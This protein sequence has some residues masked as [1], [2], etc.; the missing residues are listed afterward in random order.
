L[1]RDQIR[2]VLR[3]AQLTA[4]RLRRGVRPRLV[5]KLTVPVAAETAQWT[6]VVS[7]LSALL[8]QPA[9]RHA[10]AV[11]ILSNQF[12]RYQLLSASSARLNDKEQLARAQHVYAKLYGE[13]AAAMHLQIARAGFAAPVLV[14]GTEKALIDAIRQSFAEPSLKLVSIQPYLMSAF[15]ACCRRVDAR[16]QWFVAQEEGAIC[17]ALIHRG[18]W[19]SLRMQHTSTNWL[20]DL[21]HLLNREQVTSALAEQTRTVRICLLNG[22]MAQAP[23]I[24]GWALTLL[25]P[26]PIA[27]VSPLTDAAYHA[28]LAGAR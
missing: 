16:A 3:P 4:V 6:P 9:W 2:I 1:W 7:A 10:D 20:Q 24:D 27:G 22:D 25:Q 19:E 12:V 28:A 26:S 18:R 14:A 15:N 11:V 17:A 8:A 13:R 23:Q 21:Q 5:G